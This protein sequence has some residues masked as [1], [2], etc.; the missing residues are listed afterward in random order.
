MIGSLIVGTVVALVFL[1]AL[2]GCILGWILRPRPSIFISYRRNDTKDMADRLYKDLQA[3]FGEGVFK[4]DQ[5]LPPGKPFPA[6]LERR[7]VASD[8]VLVLVGE[9]W[10]TLRNRRRLA[11]PK[12]GVHVEVA[13]ALRLGRCVPVIV[14]GAAPEE[15]LLP[16]SLA[17]LG[18]L[19]RLD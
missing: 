19:Q 1:V 7:L 5:D 17:D 18:P 6:S 10:L 15:A 11:D 13:T 16:E 4:D 9:R 2:A 3:T 12:D 8:V 14:D